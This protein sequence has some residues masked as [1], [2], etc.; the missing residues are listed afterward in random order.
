MANKKITN[1]VNI[2]IDSEKL[3]DEILAKKHVKQQKKKAYVGKVNVNVHRT[4][5]KKKDV[6]NQKENDLIYEQILE[7]KKNKFHSQ[8]KRVSQK[9]I[10]DNYNGVY[11]SNKKVFNKIINIFIIS[12][13]CLLLLIM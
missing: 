1:K 7:K 13:S 12:L 9:V 3:L 5:Q 2:P 11:R 8:H 4:V 10:K 6:Q